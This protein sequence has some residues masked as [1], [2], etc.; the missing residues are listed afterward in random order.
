MDIGQ[1]VRSICDQLRNFEHLL[2]R[3][4]EVNKAYKQ[5]YSSS[6]GSKTGSSCPSGTTMFIDIL[7]VGIDG[8]LYVLTCLGEELLQLFVKNEQGGK[9]LICDEGK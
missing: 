7:T 4:T 8:M 5:V 6:K 3:G 1:F 9:V 2:E